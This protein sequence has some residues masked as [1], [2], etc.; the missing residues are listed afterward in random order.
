LK[1][2][3]GSASFWFA[4]KDHVSQILCLLHVEV[5][6]VTRLRGQTSDKIM[7]QQRGIEILRDE[8]MYCTH[9]HE[10]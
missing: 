3:D 6:K 4:D 2:V 1:E 10:E 8:V 7:L 5:F 9:L